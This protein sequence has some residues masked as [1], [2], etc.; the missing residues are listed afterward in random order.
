MH[1]IGM[2]LLFR[3]L[4]RREGMTIIRGLTGGGRHPVRRPVERRRVELKRFR[5]QLRRSQEAGSSTE[6]ATGATGESALFS[7]LKAQDPAPPDPH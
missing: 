6:V 3:E 2:M 5:N 4:K 7:G 1:A